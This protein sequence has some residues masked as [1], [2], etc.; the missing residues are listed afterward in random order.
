MR[1]DMKLDVK[2]L[3]SG[4]KEAK[5]DGKLDIHGALAIDDAFAELAGASKNILVDLSGVTYLASLGIRTLVQAAKTLSNN[6][7]SIVLF[8]PQEN[9]E[10]VLRATGIDTV[11]P[12]RHGREEALAL[13]SK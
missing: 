1:S 10:K 2:D 8:A 7:G 9:V 4:T 3:G 5:L 11:I 12:V 6:G 13:L